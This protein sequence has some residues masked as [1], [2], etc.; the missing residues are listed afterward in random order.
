[1]FIDRSRLCVQHRVSPSSFPHHHP[2]Y[3]TLLQNNY[4]CSQPNLTFFLYTNITHPPRNMVSPRAAS[5]FLISLPEF[6]LPLIGSFKW[7][8]PPGSYRATTCRGRELI[9]GSHIHLRPKKDINGLPRW[10]IS[11]MPEP[12]PR[13]HKYESD[14]YT[15]IHSNK[16]NIKWWLWRTNDIRG[17]CGPKVS[18]HLSYRWAK[19]PKKPHRGSNPGPLRDRRACYRL[20]HS[21]GRQEMRESKIDYTNVIYPHRA[22][23]EARNSAVGWY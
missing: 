22:E 10:W 2:T 16:A 13:Q 9:F 11:S 5:H 12:P 3:N 19:T 1:M 4:A 14:T 17:L 6:D 7:L 20:F 18:W 8:T 15:L 23:P 21:G